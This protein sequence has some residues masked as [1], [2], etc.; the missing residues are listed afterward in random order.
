[1]PPDKALGKTEWSFLP[2]GA[3]H[4]DEF[5]SDHPNYDGRGVIIYIF[6]TGVDPGIAGYRLRRMA[7]KK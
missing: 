6:D 7:N 1:M 5:V 4:A 3:T 2:L